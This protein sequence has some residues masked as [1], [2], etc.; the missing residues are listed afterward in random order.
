MK[1]TRDFLY[2]IWLVT[3]SFTKNLYAWGSKL[4]VFFLKTQQLFILISPCRMIAG[5]IV[6]QVSPG[7]DRFN[8]PAVSGYNTVLRIIFSFQNLWSF[9]INW[10][11]LN[12]NFMHRTFPSSAFLSKLCIETYAGFSQIWLVTISFTKN[13]YM[14]QSVSYLSFFLKRKNYN[15]NSNDF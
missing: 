9:W 2:Q 12:W 8:P 10:I 3:I 14:L 4:F 6:S 13:L 15:Y 5:V 7:G 11:E 1:S